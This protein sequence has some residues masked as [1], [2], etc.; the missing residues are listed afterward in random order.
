MNI[1]KR[2]NQR[3][4]IHL[5]KQEGGFLAR[6]I[7]FTERFDGS[8]IS[9]IAGV[10]N[11]TTEQALEL[12]ARSETLKNFNI[13]IVEDENSSPILIGLPSYIPSVVFSE[14]FDFIPSPYSS[15]INIQE[16]F[17]ST[18]QTRGPNSK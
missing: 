17:F 18:Q 12:K 16:A 14:Q 15:K 7:V 8:C 1:V 13:V 5:S 3:A 9:H 6:F 10:E 11:L 2:N 4:V